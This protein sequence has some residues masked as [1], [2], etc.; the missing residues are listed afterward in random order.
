VET[1]APDGLAVSITA[2]VV[3]CGSVS[4]GPRMG[5]LDD[6]PAGHAISISALTET[7]HDK[8]ALFACL[9]FKLCMF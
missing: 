2:E 4:F 6:D 5:L 1:F 8:R 3:Q 9:S 7:T